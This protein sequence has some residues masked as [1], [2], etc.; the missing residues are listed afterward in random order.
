MVSRKDTHEIITAILGYGVRRYG[1]SLFEVQGLGYKVLGTGLL[2]T[3]V[4]GTG[5]NV[6][7]L[8]VQGTGYRVQSTIYAKKKDFFL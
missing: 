8:G 3:G 4:K 5:Y 2:S 1:K 6:L 7:G